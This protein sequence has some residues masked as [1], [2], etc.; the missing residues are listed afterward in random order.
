M[1][2]IS[3]F[4][5][6]FYL[7][8]FFTETIL[9]KEKTK[10]KPFSNLLEQDIFHRVL[11]ACCLEIVIF[12]YNSP[13][14]TFPWILN[15]FELKDFDFYKVIE[16]II[17]AE[18]W[19]PREIVK[20]LQSIEEQILESRAWTSTSPLWDAIERD[21]NGVPGWEDVSLP[22]AGGGGGSLIQDVTQSPVS[23]LGRPF[24]VKS[25]MAGDRFK[26][27]VVTALARRQL[28]FDGTSGLTVTSPI[29]AGQSILA[30]PQKP[31][32]QSP[33]KFHI[34]QPTDNVTL[35]SEL[36]KSKRTGSLALFFRKVYTCAN[37][38]LEHLCHG[39]NITDETFRRKIWTTFEYVLKE[40]TDMMKDRHMDQ[41]LMCSMYII[42]KIIFMKKEN[43]NEGVFNKII[44]QYKKQPQAE[45]HVYESV[46]IQ[47]EK[48][49]LI[50]KNKKDFAL[51]RYDYFS[52]DIVQDCPY[53][54]YHFLGFYNAVFLKRVKDYIKRYHGDGAMAPLSPMP[55]MKN[56]P[57]PS[58]IRKVSDSHPVYIRP[59]KVNPQDEVV[60]QPKSPHRP[61]CYS[62]SRSPAKVKKKN[63]N[64]IIAI[65]I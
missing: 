5:I 19:L 1:Y 25:P 30:S 12:S 36:H 47:D 29:K 35:E 59:L 21:P 60:F 4:Y 13:S 40:Q 20:H 10:N 7:P 32:V 27:P 31:V 11:F 58:P 28:A 16:V 14:R 64:L 52:L 3:F 8:F 22:N 42:W 33:T 6:Y 54:P 57:P 56:H 2:V 46:L 18:E 53:F 44:N 9:I 41:I 65:Y 34:I 63:H 62:F 45:K 37:S 51:I 43:K 49:D 23:H 15:S 50:G 55:K 39:L 38:R 26:S 24:S 61:L 48:E 17:R